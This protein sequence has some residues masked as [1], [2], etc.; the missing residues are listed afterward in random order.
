[1]EKK[2]LVLFLLLTALRDRRATAP[3]EVSIVDEG[4]MEGT[5]FVSVPNKK[6]YSR[7]RLHPGTSDNPIV[8][9]IHRNLGPCFGTLPLGPLKHKDSGTLIFLSTKGTNPSSALKE[10]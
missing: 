6:K 7:A 2:A 9:R 3:R 10:H 1:M 8:P 5:T 4:M